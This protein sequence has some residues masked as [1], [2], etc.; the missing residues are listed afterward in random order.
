MG[1][2]CSRK[3]PV[4]EHFELN[5]SHDS[6]IETVKIKYVTDLLFK[7]APR[8]LKTECN[9]IAVFACQN[10]VRWFLNLLTTFS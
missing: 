3:P 4:D 7:R 5:C 9:L 6:S 1:S 2:L 10:L 8:P